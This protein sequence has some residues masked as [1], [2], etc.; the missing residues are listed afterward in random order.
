MEQGTA[1]SGTPRQKKGMDAGL[2]WTFIVLGILL[3]GGLV[4]S[5]V[6]EGR[7][8]GTTGVGPLLIV[9]GIAEHPK[10]AGTRAGR[11]FLLLLAVAVAAWFVLRFVL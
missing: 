1:P 2:A 7:A 3:T 4:W 6:Q 11:W 8:T 10:V 5:V 9:A